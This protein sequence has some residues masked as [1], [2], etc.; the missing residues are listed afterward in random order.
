MTST[1]GL[2]RKIER[3]TQGLKA[4]ATDLNHTTELVREQT[5][6]VSLYRECGVPEAA[7]L[8]EIE[9]LERGYEGWENQSYSFVAI[10][11]FEAAQGITHYFAR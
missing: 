8:A 11:L 10:R 7:R 3:A 2:I 6:L 5:L 9:S 4:L 1:E